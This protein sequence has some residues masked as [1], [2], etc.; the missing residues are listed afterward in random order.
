MPETPPSRPGPRDSSKAPGCR[1]VFK[2]GPQKGERCTLRPCLKDGLC[3]LHSRMRKNFEQLRNFGAFLRD[4]VAKGHSLEGIVLKEGFFQNLDLV[5][6]QMPEADLTECRMVQCRLNNANLANSRMVGAELSSANFKGANLS[7]CC[8][9]QGFLIESNLEGADLTMASIVEADLEGTN[10]RNANLENA[11]LNKANL[12]GAILEGAN[13]RGASLID[14]NL[15]CAN[16][17]N[18]NVKNANLT[19]VQVNALTV[20]TGIKN[21]RSTIRPPDEWDDTDD[22]SSQR[23][24]NPSAAAV[25]SAPAAARPVPASRPV[26]RLL[27][28][29]QFGDEKEY[30]II[31]RL[32]K[33]GSAFVYLVRDKT[34]KNTP[35]KA[36]KILDPNLG[37]EEI[38][39]KRFRREGEIGQKLNHPN[40]INVFDVKYATQFD[41]FYLVMEFIEGLDLKAYLKKYLNSNKPFPAKVGIQMVFQICQGLRVAHSNNIIHRDLKPGNI[42]IRRDG[43]V[44]VTDFGLSKLTD[45]LGQTRQMATIPGT[46]LGTFEYM[47]PEQVAG[48]EV[49]TLTDIYSLGVIMYEMF[50]GQLPYKAHN[51][52]AWVN[53]IQHK[54]PQNPREINPHFPNWLEEIILRC[55]EKDSIKRFQDIKYLQESIKQK[56]VVV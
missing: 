44:V 5:G 28:D 47:S 21:L 41:T 22:I 49:S 39:V 54:V 1:Y 14:V 35:I 6:A 40:I 3:L 11:N 20:Y 16:L 33:G 48:D 46:L 4:R 52:L 32:G 8:I 24:V 51:V 36:I 13:L 42:L 10:L 7:N 43:R 26:S 27:P 17:S 31:R 19:G 34:D 18:A 29:D 45:P 9:D 37:A 50:V 25:A 55:L 53:V 23:I 38:N 12:F 30:R 2:Y 56:K 15:E